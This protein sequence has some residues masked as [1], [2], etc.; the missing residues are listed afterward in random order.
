MRDIHDKFT[1]APKKRGRKPSGTDAMSAAKRK[2]EQRI[3]QA[4]AIQ[5]R[6]NHE[7]TDAECL[8]ILTGARWRGGAIDKGAWEQLGKLRGFLSDNHEITDAF[9]V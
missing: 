6:D 8:S 7:W 1:E 5:N 9:G 4:E 2:R 3:R